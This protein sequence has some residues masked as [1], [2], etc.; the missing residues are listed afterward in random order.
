MNT[1]MKKAI[2]YGL[3]QNFQD[4]KTGIEKQ[5]EVIGYSDK[6]YKQID[7]YISPGQIRNYEF[8]YIIITSW[9]HY[10]SIKK[11]LTGKYCISDEKIVGLECVR[12]TTQDKVIVIRFMGGMG[13]ML[14]HYALMKKMEIL[15]PDVPVKADISSYYN[16]VIYTQDFNVLWTFERMFGK[17]LPIATDQDITTAKLNGYYMEKEASK[18]DDNVLKYGCGYYHGYWQTGKYFEDCG[19]LRDEL[20]NIDILTVSAH[21]RKILK[22]I[23]ECESAA[24]WVRR[25]DYINNEVNRDYYGGICTEEYY[26]N[27][28]KYLREKYPDVVFFVFSNDAEYIKEKYKDMNVITYDDI[29]GE[30]KEYNIY[31]ISQCKHIIQANSSM[32][33][34]ACWIHGNAGTIISPRKWSNIDVCPD[35][36]E[37]YWVRM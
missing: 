2:V 25:G 20:Q 35:V 1:N 7:K 17:K 13:N 32:S 24:I 30:Y 27:A 12:D 11:D 16:E 23:Q 36:H 29:S 21:Q 14:F 5:Y 9:K 33:W 28:I 6:E 4:Y 19:F 18:F 8:D 10:G 34:W 22:Q 15:Y 31:L 26:D 3:G 37:D